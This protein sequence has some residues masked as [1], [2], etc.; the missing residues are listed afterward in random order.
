M[1]PFVLVG[2]LKGLDLGIAPLLLDLPTEGTLL[3]GEY[4][5]PC[6]E[7]ALQTLRTKP[8]TIVLLFSSASLRPHNSQNVGII[9]NMQFTNLAFSQLLLH[10]HIQ[11]NLSYIA[12]VFSDP[13]DIFC[14]DFDSINLINIFKF[15]CY[16]YNALF[17][18]INVT[19]FFD[20]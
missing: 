8:S 11:Y 20:C 4:G 16:T 6:F 14:N 5:L 15:A 18:I 19:R 13:S 2:F 3:G 9:P 7:Q 17:Q 12:S 10:S 1:L